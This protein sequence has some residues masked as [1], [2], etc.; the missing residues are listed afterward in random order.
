[1]AAAVEAGFPATLDVP[2]QAGVLCLPGLGVVALPGASVARVSSSA[3][4][5]EFHVRPDV[6]EP[7]TSTGSGSPTTWRSV[8]PVDVGGPR[9][10]LDDVDPVRDCVAHPAV[11]ALS[12]AERD[13][14]VALLAQAALT[15]V[16]VGMVHSDNRTANRIILT[17]FA[18]GVGAAVILIASHSRPFSG[19]ISVKPDLLLQVMPGATQSPGP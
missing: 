11:D 18:T 14:W 12:P 9:V 5:A 15:L 8:R 13:E 6:G 3:R 16:A 7:W 17:I 2:V 4:S 19:E 10:R 1:M